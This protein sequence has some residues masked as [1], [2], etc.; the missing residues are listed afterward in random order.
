MDPALNTAIGVLSKMEIP[1]HSQVLE[2]LPSV[3]RIQLKRPS[4]ALQLHISAMLLHSL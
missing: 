2:V 1:G 4:W 3:S